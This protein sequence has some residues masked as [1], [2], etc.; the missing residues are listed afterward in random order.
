MQN[1]NKQ[2]KTNFKTKKSERRIQLTQAVAALLFGDFLKIEKR[3]IHIW[4]ADKQ[5]K[6][7]HCS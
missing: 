2:K 6:L 5:Q 4:I 7:Q 3:K 1:E